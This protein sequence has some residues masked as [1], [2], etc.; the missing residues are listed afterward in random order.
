[1]Q[2]GLSCAEQG[3]ECP[4]CL[5][6]VSFCLSTLF[7]KIYYFL[8]ISSFSCIGSSLPPTGFLSLHRAGAALRCAVWASTSRLGSVARGLFLHGVW[9]TPGAGTEPVSPSLAGGFLTTGPPGK[10]ISTLFLIV[11][12][13]YF[14]LW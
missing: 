10:P 5:S 6:S 14:L 3:V 1:M 2:L 7:L 9:G 12:G 4:P 11:C 13:N 8:L